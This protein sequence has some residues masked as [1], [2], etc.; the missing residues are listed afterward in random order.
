MAISLAERS[1]QLDAEQRLLVKADRDIEEGC[2]RIRKQEDRVREFLA[3]GHDTDQAQ[4]L[5]ELLKKTLIEW[6]RH[7]VLI[8]QRVTYLQRQLAAGRP[9]AG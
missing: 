8:A 7:R 1:Q 6:Q 4:Q 3:C 5:V 2:Q 9:E